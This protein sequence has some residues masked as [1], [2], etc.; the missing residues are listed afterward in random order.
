M[1][2]TSVRTAGASI[3]MRWLPGT[4]RRQ[5]LSRL[6]ASTAAQTVRA[7]IGRSLP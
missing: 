7:R 3:G 2:S 5:P 6:D 4:M 1:F